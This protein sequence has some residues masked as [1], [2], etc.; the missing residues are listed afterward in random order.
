[1]SP[2]HWSDPA[3]VN[4]MLWVIIDRKERDA[5]E[6]RDEALVQLLRPTNLT[7]PA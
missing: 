2:V 4:Y 6:Q 3:W 7:E 5:R 1:M